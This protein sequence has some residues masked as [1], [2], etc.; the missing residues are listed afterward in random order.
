MGDG[1]ESGLHLDERPSPS[2]PLPPSHSCSLQP[3]TDSVHRKRAF[4]KNGCPTAA[5][6]RGGRKQGL[7]GWNFLASLVQTGQPLD[8][9]RRKRG[10]GGKLLHP[11]WLSKSPAEPVKKPDWTLYFV[12]CSAQQTGHI[13]ARCPP[14]SALTEC[15]CHLMPTSGSS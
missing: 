4:P 12:L 14:G 11:T 7:R 1:H 13:W 6:Q 15:P 2:L 8:L 3:P 9:H 10:Q 5:G